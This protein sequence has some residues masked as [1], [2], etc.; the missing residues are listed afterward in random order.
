V[1]RWRVSAIA[2]CTISSGIYNIYNAA[3]IFAPSGVPGPV[4]AFQPEPAW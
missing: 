1:L 3:R 4:H 2:V